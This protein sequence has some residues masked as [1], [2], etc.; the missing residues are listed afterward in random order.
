MLLRRNSHL[1][2]LGS[3]SSWYWEFQLRI[4]VI[5][6]VYTNKLAPAYCRHLA[7]VKLGLKMNLTGTSKEWI[8][9]ADDTVWIFSLN[10]S[11]GMNDIISFRFLYKIDHEIKTLYW[12]PSSAAVRNDWNWTSTPPIWLHGLQKDRVTI[13]FFFFFFTMKRLKL[14]MFFWPCITV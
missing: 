11:A 9:T 4:S 8:R 12:I 10:P 7:V 3:N 1:E 14:L 6:T 2:V 13:S 5:Y